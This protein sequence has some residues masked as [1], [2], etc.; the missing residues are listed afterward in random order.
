MAVGNMSA[1][2][3]GTAWSMKVFPQASSILSLADA[4]SCTSKSSCTAVGSYAN[5]SKGTLTLIVNWNGTSWQQQAAQN[6]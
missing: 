6:P 3:N 4:V 2:W 1:V 5:L